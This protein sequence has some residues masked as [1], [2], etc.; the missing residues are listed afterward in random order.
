M[1]RIKMTKSVIDKLPLVDKGAIAYFD[2]EMPGFA[3]RVGKTKKTFFVQRDIR[4]RTHVSTIGTYGLWTPDL[5]R[6]EARERLLML[7]K[8]TCW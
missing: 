8:G 6:Q 3:I 5:A 4:G 2:I 1:P 7:T